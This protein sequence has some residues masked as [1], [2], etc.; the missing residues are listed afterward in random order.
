MFGTSAAASPATPKRHS[1]SPPTTHEKSPI[2]LF[3]FAS[4]ASSEDKSDVLK[5]HEAGREDFV[6]LDDRE[7]RWVVRRLVTVFGVGMKL[8]CMKIE[9][10]T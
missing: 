3:G 1:F 7:R 5:V 8:E 9:R 4:C 2:L 6:R 10:S